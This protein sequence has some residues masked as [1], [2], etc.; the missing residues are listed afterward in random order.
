[1]GIPVEDG[2]GSLQTSVLPTVGMRI[3]GCVQVWTGNSGT[4]E[5]RARDTQGDG[6]IELIGEGGDSQRFEYTTGLTA[7]L[8]VDVQWSEPRDTTL[9][10]WVGLEGAAR[11]GSAACEPRYSE[12]PPGPV[13][14]PQSE[15]LDLTPMRS[16]GAMRVQQPR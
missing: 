7:Q 3:A 14:Q 13:P 2:R 4:W 10:V 11:R 15:D 12:Q 8:D 1:M 16:D 6:M 5:I 9:L